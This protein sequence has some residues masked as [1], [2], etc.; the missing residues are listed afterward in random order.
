MLL[1]VVVFCLF[2][3]GDAASIGNAPFK[4]LVFDPS[5]LSDRKHFIDLGVA[6]GS[7][8]T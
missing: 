1:G 6:A 2:F 8:L 3:G 5:L 4:L 7:E